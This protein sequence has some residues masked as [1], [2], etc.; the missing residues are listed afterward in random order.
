MAIQLLIAPATAG[1]TVYVLDFGCTLKEC[2]LGAPI[3]LEANDIFRCTIAKV[4]E[5]QY[6]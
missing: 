2:E 6:R 3:S 1:K 5:A 4:V